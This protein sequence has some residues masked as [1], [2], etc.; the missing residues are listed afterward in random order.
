[1]YILFEDGAFM[2]IWCHWLQ[3]NILG[4]SR[5]IVHGTLSNF[6]QLWISSAD[7]RRSVQYQISRKS[8]P[9]G[10]SCYIRTDM[11]KWRHSLLCER[12][13]LFHLCKAR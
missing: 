4:V 13:R 8:F 1:L 9:W 10:P 2:T 5:K 7:F 6:H 12:A 3:W 11:A